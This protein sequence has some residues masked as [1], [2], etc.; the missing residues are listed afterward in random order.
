MI[1]LIRISHM[2]LPFFFPYTQKCSRI[3]LKEKDRQD[4]LRRMRNPK[5]EHLKKNDILKAIVTKC[6]A[7]V[8]SKKA[9]ECSRC[10]YVNG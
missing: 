9:V 8:G 3:L 1:L 2:I 4:F 6:N 5:L 7:M 10:G